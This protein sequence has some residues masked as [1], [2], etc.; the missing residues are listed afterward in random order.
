[1]V[2]DKQAII[3]ANADYVKTY[4][5]DKNPSPMP[6]K[7]MAISIPHLPILHSSQ[8]PASALA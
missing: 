4:S 7:K 3:A 5:D 1:M 6:R 8:P 2:V